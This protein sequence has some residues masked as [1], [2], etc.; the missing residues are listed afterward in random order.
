MRTKTKGDDNAEATDRKDLPGMSYSNNPAQGRYLLFLDILGFSELVKT[1]GHDEVLGIVTNALEAFDRWENLNQQFRTIYFSDTF[2]FYQVPKGY[3]KWAFLDVYAIGG[4]ILTALLAKGIAARG[5]I[6]F[7]GFE[8]Q[9]STLGKH[10]VYFGPALIEAYQ[11]EQKEG[12]LGITIQPSAWLPC[13][14]D[15]PG[16]I[17]A[18]ER[19]RVWIKRSD[20]VLLL[21]PFIKLRGWHIHDLIG[22]IDRPYLEWDQPDFPNEILAFKF[23]REQ[24]DFFTRSGDFTGRVASKYHATD[25]FLKQVFGPD[26]FAWACKI[27]E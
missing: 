8:V 2:V 3:G 19:E 25:A 7:G 22:E 9:D 11:A 18:F 6:T 21:N 12:W 13:E 16:I 5:A 4:L 10:Q 23:L 14:A 26:L 17:Q 20:D 24:A 27:S 1:K 15:D